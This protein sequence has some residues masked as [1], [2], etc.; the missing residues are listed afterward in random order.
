MVARSKW[1]LGAALLLVVTAAA[2]DRSPMAADGAMMRRWAEELDRDASRTREQIRTMRQLPPEQWHARMNE[3]AGLVTGMIDHMERRMDEMGQ[4]GGMHMGG[5][6][7]RA[8]GVGSMMG[9][10][11]EGHREMLNRMQTLRDDIHQLRSAAPAEVME[12]MPGHLE[13]LDEM[14]RMMEQGAAHMRAMGMNGGK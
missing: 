12:R 2:C 13:R 5:M 8:D 11:A 7:M 14:A 10:S 4:M 6:G 9:M 1:T 3:H